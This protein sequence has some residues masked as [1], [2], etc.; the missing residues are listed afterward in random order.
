M[1]RRE[2]GT[3]ASAASSLWPSVVGAQKSMPLIGMLLREDI[4]D[5]FVQEMR[6]L[7][8]VEG[9][10]VRYEFRP[11]TPADALDRRAAE[12]V[13]LKV[14]VIV[15]AGTEAVRA[16]QHRTE[17]IPIVT[18]GASDP[19]GS[20][21]AVSL[22][23]PGR[24]VTG[25]SLYNSPELTAK[26]IELLREA[27]GSLSRIVVLFNPD[28]PPAMLALKETEAAS[29]ALGISTRAVE[30]RR[31]E[32]FDDAFAAALGSPADAVV[33]LSA[34]LMTGNVRR[35]AEW[36]RQNRLPAIFWSR[37]FPAAGGLMSYG[38]NFDDL[39]KGAAGYVDRIL[40]GAKAGDL[41]IVQPA[42][43]QLVINNRTAK[44]FGLVLPPSILTRADEVID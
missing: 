39:V 6:A 35:I 5:R 25:M 14:E 11:L 21:L 27:V 22:A 33:A 32:A 17:T 29:R 19:V 36:T 9:K 3:L 23:R 42:T 8:Y 16:A 38:P 7:G 2:F 18:T 30:V 12:L 37:T 24:N 4:R 34:P 41:P 1:R 15:A 40:K 28:D 31:P 10:T 13:S 43:L 44:T 20:G 26:R